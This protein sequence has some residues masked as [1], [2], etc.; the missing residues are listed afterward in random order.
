MGKES[1]LDHN[2]VDT[3][4]KVLQCHILTCDRDISDHYATYITLSAQTVRKSARKL[5]TSRAYHKFNPIEF[6]NKAKHLPFLE[7]AN[8]TSLSVHGRAELIDSY[9]SDLYNQHV[10][11]RQIRVR[12]PKKEWLNRNLLHLINLKN[13]FYR[14]VFQSSHSVTDS[15]IAHYRKFKNYV[16]N[17]IRKAKKDYFS[18]KLSE[19]TQSFFKCLKQFSGKERSSTTIDSL[20]VNQEV[21]KNDSDIAHSLNTFFTSIGTK[22]EAKLPPPS[23]SI[24]SHE[25]DNFN[26]VPTTSEQV[27]QCLNSLNSRKRGGLNQIPAAIYK[28]IAVLLALPLTT[29]INQS[30]ETGEFPDIL[31]I[32]LVT[33]IYKKGDKTDPANYRPISSLPILSKVFETIMKNQLLAY[34]ENNCLLSERQFGYRTNHSS[35]QLLQAL[36]TDWRLSL[37]RKSP[38]YISALSLDVR[39]AFDSVN[40]S[41]ILAKLKQFHLSCSAI[42]LLKSYLTNRLQAMR[43]GSTNSPLLPI[44]CGVPQSSILGPLLFL[45]TVNDLLT[46]FPSSFAYADDTLIFSKGR[47]AEEAITNCESLFQQVTV[48]YQKNLLQLNISKTQLCIFT[49]RNL[50]KDYSISYGGTKIH[51]RST[52]SVLGI[53]LDSG[54]TFTPHIEAIC[55]KAN[56]LIY[57]SSK[58]RKF[59]TIEQAS[60]VYTSI[61]RPTVE[62]CSSLFLEVSQKPPTLLKKCKIGPL[63]LLSVLQ[64]SVPLR[65][66]ASCLIYR[67]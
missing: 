56:S 23:N 36:L 60:L 20:I 14:R 30:F 17:Q 33:P 65:L 11:I 37:D 59:L 66:A 9:I 29:L 58:L 61:I 26:F 42:K 44:T 41:L 4:L 6:F 7:I 53:L 54:L 39:K 32:A 48:W 50:T 21:V 31:K 67:H 24:P 18:N 34:M 12:G 63:E 51:N 28:C 3:D 40:H 27:F 16:Q 22:I 55:H 38:M 52:M 10:P 49:N 35:E 45:I 47:S 62:Y 8:D 25:F 13:K 57:L 43:V 46:L 15:Q 1:L 19:N 64:E 2:Y 5:I